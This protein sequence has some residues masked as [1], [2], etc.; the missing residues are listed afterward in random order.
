MSFKES[1][2]M[3]QKPAQRYLVVHLWCPEGYGTDKQ[4]AIPVNSKV[5]KMQ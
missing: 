5:V 3:V 1:S 2:S 4:S